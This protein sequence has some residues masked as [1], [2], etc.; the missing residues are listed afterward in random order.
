MNCYFWHPW[1]FV[2][3]FQDPVEMFLITCFASLSSFFTLLLLVM[4]SAMI[5]GP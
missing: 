1:V 3:R 5:Y 4:S 2:Q